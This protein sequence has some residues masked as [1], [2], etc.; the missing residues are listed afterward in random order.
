RLQRHPYLAL[1][2]G[3][4][5]NT[6]T[7]GRTEATV[8]LQALFFLNN[9]WLGEQARGMA[10]RL[11]AE[12]SD[13]RTRIQLA[14]RMAWGREAAADE[15]ERMM[16]FLEKARQELSQTGCTANELELASWTSYARVLLRSNEFVY[17]D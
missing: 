13:S 17:L 14:C 4:D 8:P 2:D 11:I 3:P 12:A 16:D 6:S 5:T 1:F 7:A 9:S 10:T 15:S